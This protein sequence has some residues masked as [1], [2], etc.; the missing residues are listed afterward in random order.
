MVTQ[1][2]PHMRNPQFNMS[3][4]N[5][6]EKYG[7]IHCNNAI[8]Q[9]VHGIMINKQMQKTHISTRWKSCVSLKS[10]QDC[11]EVII[12]SYISKAEL[13]VHVWEKIPRKSKYVLQSK[14]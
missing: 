1:M 12:P 9:L 11:G 3:A 8:V 13:V 10:N 5:I 2:L 6:D 7:I 14:V 4:M